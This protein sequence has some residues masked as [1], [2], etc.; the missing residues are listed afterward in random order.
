MTSS[1]RIEPVPDAGPVSLPEPLPFGKVFTRRMF[2]QRYAPGAGW[3]DAVIGPYRA[4][5]LDPGAQV[6]HAGQAIFEGTKAYL[7]PDG[8][9][10]L[11]RPDANG[12]RFNRS[13]ERMGMPPLRVDDF[14]ASI[15]ALVQLEHAWAPRGE[16]ASL[17]VR[18][19]MIATEATFEVRSARE[20][21]HYVVLSPAGPYFASG[22][23]PV[24]VMV[25]EDHVR[26]VRGGTGM[27][28]TPG[29]YAASL[30]GIERARSCG[31][32]QV[33]WLDAV[34]RR[35]V[36]E[37]GAMNVAFVYEGERIVT[38]GLSGSILAGIT[39]DSI[40]RLAPDLGHACVETRID[41]DEVLADID[42]GK[43]T[44]AF[45]MGTAAVVVPIGRIGYRGTDHVVGDGRSAP[46]A[47]RL[48]R[49]LTDI[50]YGR[51]EDRYGWTRCVPVPAAGAMQAA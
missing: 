14:V 22:F 39:R 11:F 51:A 27:A 30:A 16:G 10:N 2:T 21:L 23:E 48:Y 43:V 29:N 3:H 38:P 40:L 15:E 6:L 24:G 46:V 5:V 31:Y 19:V 1:I 37:A 32:Q 25:A 4:L 34:E 28:K 45:C 36:E 12:L 49:A 44:E 47:Q 18:P 9:L 35:F 17:Y 26:A 13:A 41:I 33:L 7:R 20:F 8:H 50:Q 42:A